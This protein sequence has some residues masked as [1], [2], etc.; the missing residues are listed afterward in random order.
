MITYTIHQYVFST[1]T[2]S[3]L[4]EDGS[5]LETYTTIEEAAAAARAT[6][7][8]VAKALYVGADDENFEVVES[9]D[10]KRFF[11]DDADGESI[12]EFRVVEQYSELEEA[13]TPAEIEREY[14]LASGSVRNM[15]DGI[16]HRR[17]DERTILIPRSY[18]EQRWAHRR[19]S[20]GDT[21]RVR[22]HTQYGDLRGGAVHSDMHSHQHNGYHAVK[23]VSVS[24]DGSV[25]VEVAGDMVDVVPA[26]YCE[27]INV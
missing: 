21:V 27:K 18:A 26:M 1:P 16:P 15:L 6:A 14:G 3:T 23:V 4:L 24:D 10:G 9:T 17:P 19:L 11:V 12:H 20:V 25:E 13:M 7:E 22:P 8:V 2:S 5:N